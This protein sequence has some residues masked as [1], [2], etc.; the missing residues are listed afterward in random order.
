MRS[1]RSLSFHLL[2]LS[3]VLQVL[4]L[5]DVPLCVLVDYMLQKLDI[6]MAIFPD[7][8]RILARL[9]VNLSNIYMPVVLRGGSVIRIGLL[10]AGYLCL[11]I[12]DLLLEVVVLML[13][14]I[15]A[16]CECLEVLL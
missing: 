13:E 6:K 9:Q 1:C 15:G 3:L 11:E 8:L 16:V 5:D 10:F 7:H 12:F 4:L 2:N 14:S